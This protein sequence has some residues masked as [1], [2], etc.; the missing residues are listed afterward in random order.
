MLAARIADSKAPRP[1]PGPTR[2]YEDFVHFILSEED[3][4]T[5][6]ALAYWLHCIDLDADGV[7]NVHDMR[8]GRGR[9]QGD[10]SRDLSAVRLL[11]V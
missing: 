11:A 7:I 6:A 10:E 2:S 5:D 8:C 3:K 9:G 1:H 4:T